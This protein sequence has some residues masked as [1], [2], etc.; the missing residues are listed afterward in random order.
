MRE[1]PTTNQPV[2][3]AEYVLHLLKIGR[4]GAFSCPYP[5]QGPGG[6]ASA[7]YALRAAVKHLDTWLRTGS[8]RW[9][10]GSARW[11]PKT[12]NSDR[13]NTAA[14]SRLRSCVVS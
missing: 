4:G 12:R 1:A 5:V 2:D 7:D 9:N 8:R 14:A 11:V 6:P 10:N 3:G 13:R